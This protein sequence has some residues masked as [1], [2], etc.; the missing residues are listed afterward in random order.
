MDFLD[1]LPENARTSL[2]KALEKY[3]EVKSQLISTSTIVHGSF[4]S[5]EFLV[6]MQ[7]G[8]ISLLE[9]VIQGGEESSTLFAQAMD[10]FQVMG[11]EGGLELADDYIRNFE[12]NRR[13][14][15]LAGLFPEHQASLLGPFN[16]GVGLYNQVLRNEFERDERLSKVLESV[17]LLR[18]CEIAEGGFSRFDLEKRAHERTDTHWESLSGLVV[19]AT[20]V[21]V[22]AQ[23]IVRLG[24][25]G[26]VGTYLLG[27]T[28]GLWG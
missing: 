13:L 8:T 9:G 18:S 22:V 7:D 4:L 2:E 21:F 5:E 27:L 25:V 11:I 17:T 24:G 16:R 19:A 20:S 12:D 6:E 15:A 14:H 1:A 23:I 10:R 28:R 3:L 26:A